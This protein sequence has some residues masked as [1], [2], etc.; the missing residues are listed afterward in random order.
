[1]SAVRTFFFS[2]TYSLSVYVLKKKVECNTFFLWCHLKA[3]TQNTMDNLV[4]LYT[5]DFETFANE[6]S[7]IF[8]Q[9]VTLTCDHCMFF[10][11]FLF[12]TFVLCMNKSFQHNQPHI[13]QTEGVQVASSVKI[14]EVSDDAPKTDKV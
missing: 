8:V 5:D 3:H 10:I 9:V 6:S 2:E 12:L 11:A 1:M 14:E 7:L 13:V 4:L